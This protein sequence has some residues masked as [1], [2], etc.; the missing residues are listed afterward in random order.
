MSEAFKPGHRL[1]HQR[2]DERQRE[3]GT[4]EE[5]VRSTVPQKGV[6]FEPEVGAILTVPETGDKYNLVE[7]LGQG[8]G[9]VA[10]R[11]ERPQGE[12]LVVKV[13]SYDSVD[14][15]KDRAKRTQKKF[16]RLNRALRNLGL[17]YEAHRVTPLQVA[18]IGTFVPGENLVE[19]YFNDA[20]RLATEDETLNT[21]LDV[22]ETWL[23]PLHDEGIF[24]GDLTPTNLIKTS[25]GRIVPIDFGDSKR[26]DTQTCTT[27]YRGTFGYAMTMGDDVTRQHD[28]YSLGQIAT[29]LLG[30]EVPEHMGTKKYRDAYNRDRLEDLNASDP[31][32]RL[33]RKMLCVDGQFENAQE[34][35]NDLRSVRG[36]ERSVD[37]E[38]VDDEE[39]LEIVR[40]EEAIVQLGMSRRQKIYLSSCVGFLASGGLKIFAPQLAGPA[41]LLALISETVLGGMQGT[42]CVIKGSEA[43]S[44]SRE[45]QAGDELHLLPLEEQLIKLQERMDSREKTLY[46]NALATLNV[47]LAT[48]H[49]YQ[50]GDSPLATG[51]GFCASL[52][53]LGTLGEQILSYRED[54]ADLRKVNAL[55]SP[56]D[57]EVPVAT[58]EP[59]RGWLGR[60]WDSTFR[61]DGHSNRY[62]ARLHGAKLIAETGESPRERLEDALQK[63]EGDRAHTKLLRHADYDQL[64]A[65]HRVNRARYLEA[66]L[67]HSIKYEK[68]EKFG[69]DLKEYRGLLDLSEI[70]DAKD[71]ELLNSRLIVRKMI[72][73]NKQVTDTRTVYDSYSEL[74]G[75][76]PLDGKAQGSLDSAMYAAHVG[77]KDQAFA[78]LKYFEKN[79]KTE[80]PEGI[81][82]VKDL[83]QKEGSNRG[84]M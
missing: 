19:H 12:Y 59:V 28:Y 40:R 65:K 36:L 69:R 58:K 45:K 72:T 63:A 46:A 62:L 16:L 33:L 54:K 67:E 11:A 75:K 8:G 25:E 71:P 30:A 1:A 50:I 5:T 56:E 3:A 49:Y 55:M 61:R 78:H 20:N 83:L 57:S 38:L 15:A 79:H 37:A 26:S 48:L 34:L 76:L 29:V 64:R 80:L 13:K 70:P 35:V 53:S 21:L 7:K 32:K 77:N 27:Q 52:L 31:V 84:F 73:K 44:D 82:M 23:V 17:S 66:E 39:I 42:D 14:A 10:F 2:E 41:Y 24:H 74:V 22:A 4:L 51:L 68:L 6:S 18:T 9:G 47:F 60:Q 81:E 43:L